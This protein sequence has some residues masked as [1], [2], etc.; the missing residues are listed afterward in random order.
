MV[1]YIFIYIFFLTIKGIAI[2]KVGKNLLLTGSHLQLGIFISWVV[3]FSCWVIMISFYA[4]LLW[5]TKGYY[6][7]LN[8][9]SLFTFFEQVVSLAMWGKWHWNITW[10]SA[11]DCF[12][13]SWGN[14]KLWFFIQS[15]RITKYI[16]K[17]IGPLI[18]PK[19]LSFD[20]LNFHLCLIMMVNLNYF[21][22][23][24]RNKVVQDLFPHCCSCFQVF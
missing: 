9:F 16:K 10:K 18:S 14:V 6:G 11:P 2:L 3:F 13:H 15:G 8:S 4:I 12:C 24:Q 23:N 1:C 21:S 19:L 20:S 7:N 17:K 5:T 22:I